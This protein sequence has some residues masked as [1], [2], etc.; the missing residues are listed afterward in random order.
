MKP[1]TASVEKFEWL[2]VKP[3][4]GRALVV[5]SYVTD[6]KPDRRLRYP[7]AIGIDMRE[8][9]GVDRVL[10]LEDPLPLDLYRF[11]HIDCISVL[12]H[13]RRPWLMAQNIERLLN[14][15]GSLYITAP[16]A[17]RVHAYPDDYFRFTIN[18]VKAL[19]TKIDW[20]AACWASVKLSEDYRVRRTEVMNHPYIART[21]V[22]LFGRRQ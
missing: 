7:D 11:A 1:R 2:H 19:F 10:D 16:F 17:W 21:E 4:P 20:T 14:S 18:G 6:N 15:G 3:T 22:C 5:G 13:S 9:P 8:G 12:E